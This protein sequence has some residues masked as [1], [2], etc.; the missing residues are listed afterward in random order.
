MK[1]TNCIDIIEVYRTNCGSV[2]Q[3]NKTNTYILEFL[4]S[5]T[6]FKAINFLDFSKRVNQL[7][8]EEMIFS[9]LAASDVALIMP[10]YCDRCFVLTLTEVLNL[11]ELL[12]GAKFAL[13]LNSVIWECLQPM[14]F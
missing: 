10:A 3:C 1:Q 8:L 14:A 13:H 11:Q 12:S 7:D 2:S 9:T 5:S 4:G 6:A